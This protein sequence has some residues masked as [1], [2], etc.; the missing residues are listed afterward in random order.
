MTRSPGELTLPCEGISDLVVKISRERRPCW[1]CL[2][3][4]CGIS[5]IFAIVTRPISKLR[6][7]MG[8]IFLCFIKVAIFPH[9]EW[10]FRLQRIFFGSS[11]D[12]GCLSMRI[13]PKHLTFI[14]INIKQSMKFLFRSDEHIFPIIAAKF[15]EKEDRN[16]W[17]SYY[18][19]I[20][21]IRWVESRSFDC[22]GKMKQSKFALSEEGQS[23]LDIAQKHL[24]SVNALLQIFYFLSKGQLCDGVRSL[25]LSSREI[26]IAYGV[27]LLTRNSTRVL[28]LPLH[29]QIATVVLCY[30]VILCKHSCSIFYG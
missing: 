10:D 25:M 15:F 30:T 4:Y 8:G 5:E 16:R 19:R 7:I 27:F 2:Q 18:F 22:S 9:S 17:F 20:G 13:S 28:Y 6:N 14:F 3:T 11:G 29:P 21:H 23:L 1:T 26:C 24:A 12:I